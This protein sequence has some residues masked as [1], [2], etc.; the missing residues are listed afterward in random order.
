MHHNG[1]LLKD[2]L[3][4]NGAGLVVCHSSGKKKPGARAGLSGQA[5]ADQTL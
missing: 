2:R 4:H 3:F 1:A 5:A